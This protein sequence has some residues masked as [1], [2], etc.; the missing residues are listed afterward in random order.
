MGHGGKGGEG[1]VGVQVLADIVFHSGDGVQ[2]PFPLVLGVELHHLL[3]E[4]FQIAYGFFPG[5]VGLRLEELPKGDVLFD[6]FPKIPEVHVLLGA[7][8]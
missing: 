3:R 2:K 8:C 1:E 7:D 4:R 5:A 6:L